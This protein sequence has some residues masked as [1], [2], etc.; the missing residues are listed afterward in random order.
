MDVGFSCLQLKAFCQLSTWAVGWFHWFISQSEMQQSIGQ[1]VVKCVSTHQCTSTFP[2]S[3]LQNHNN[4]INS[5]LDRIERLSDYISER[6]YIFTTFNHLAL[7][8]NNALCS[9]YGVLKNQQTVT[10]CFHEI[11]LMSIPL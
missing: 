6:N 1:G 5:P 7:W 4:K 8:M 9:K 3:H 10:I 2:P 11:K